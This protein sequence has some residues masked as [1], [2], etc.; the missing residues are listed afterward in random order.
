MADGAGVTALHLVT[1]W[2]WLASLQVFIWLLSLYIGGARN[3][4]H[5]L[6]LHLVDLEA[7]VIFRGL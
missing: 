1:H 7:T 2:L 4:V 3:Q 5:E 6:L